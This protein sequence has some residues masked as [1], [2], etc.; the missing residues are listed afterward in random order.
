MSTE[1][2]SP[3]F[4]ELDAWN[5]LDVLRALHEGQLAAVAA[6]GPALPAI[7]A[8]AEAA[9]PRLRRGGRLVYAGAGTSARI[10]VQ[11]GA[12]LPPTFSWPEHR[13]AF[14]VAGGQR[15]ILQAVENAEDSTADAETQ[16]AA[17]AIGAD[18]VVIGLAA[19]GTTPFTLA[20]LR[21]AAARGALTIGLANNPDSPVLRA[22]AH[23]V[24][25]DTGEEVVAGSTRLKAGTA[26]KVVLNLFSTLVMVRLGRVYRGRMVDM[27]A[28]NSKLRHRAEA[29]VAELAEVEP[30]AARQALDAAGGEVKLAILLA[31][32][33]DRAAAEDRLARGDGSLRAALAEASPAGPGT[34]SPA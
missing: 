23:P 1:A 14:L 24:A 16:V 22:S 8:A 10:G 3:R 34:G 13:L 6:V 30:A 17:A 27:R 21:A 11:D 31:L 7:A 33:F 25:V 29:M 5:S 2:H 12:E 20:V 15:A 26:Q 18:D 32:G 19:S 9:V 4:A 28:T